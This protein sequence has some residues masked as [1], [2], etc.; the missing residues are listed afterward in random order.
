MKTITWNEFL[1]ICKEI[2]ENDGVFYSGAPPSYAIVKSCL[3]R[4]QKAPKMPLLKVASQ[5]YKLYKTEI[6]KQ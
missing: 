6:N 1:K 3:F 5:A 2:W 4:R